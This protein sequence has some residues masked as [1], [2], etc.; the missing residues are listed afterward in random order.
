[1]GM[2]L[3]QLWKHPE[4]EV[5]EEQQLLNA[6]NLTAVVERGL[7]E[8]NLS[9][10][11]TQL[12]SI[13]SRHADDTSYIFE[14][15]SNVSNVVTICILLALIL[16]CG[17]GAAFEFTVAVLSP[18]RLVYSLAVGACLLLIA[19][20]NGVFIASNVKKIQLYKRYEQYFRLL[21]FHHIELVRD[22]AA[23]AAAPIEVVKKDL[24]QAVQFKWVPQGHFSTDGNA[25]ILTDELFHK[26]MESQGDYDNYFQKLIERRE[27]ESNRTDEIQKVMEQGEKYTAKFRNYKNT[28]KDT[29]ITAK[30][31]R[32]ENVVTLIFHEVDMDPSSAKKLS[33]FLN[34]YLPTTEK[35]LNAYQDSGEAAG[36][37]TNAAKMRV[38]IEN[39]LDMINTGYEELLNQFFRE[40]EL[41]IASD[42]QVMKQVMEG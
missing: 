4:P 13:V 34:Y 8:H 37:G 42:I 41:D 14:H 5:D 21:K 32:L 23:Y 40:K 19:V 1:M 33:M 35:L 24:E 3:F 27:R 26:Y 39:A 9:E 2:N 17:L 6:E 7:K 36:M 12:K 30:V 15:P 16:C 29:E 31:E 38:E 20:L 10:M 18:Q 25:F 11:N 28:I 22:L